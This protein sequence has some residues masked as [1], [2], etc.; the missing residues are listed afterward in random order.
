MGVN[1]KGFYPPWGYQEENNYESSEIIHENDLNSFFSGVEYNNDDKKIHFLNKDGEERATLD[2]TEFAPSVVESTSYDPSTKILTITFTNGSTVEINMAELIDETEFGDGLTVEGGI[3]KI[4]IDQSGEPYLSV[5]EDGIKISGINQAIDDAVEI[6]KNR[7]ESAETELQAAIEA[8]GQRAQDVESD[9]QDAIDQE[10]ADRIADV[11]AEE[12][13]AKAAE[14]A[15]LTRATQTEQQLNHRIDVVND[16]LDSEE[17]R[18]AAAEQEIRANLA[19]EIN[20]RIA[21]VDAE[22]A[23]AKASE[24]E[25][26]DKINDIISGNTPIKRL[27]DLIEK[28]GYSNNETLVTNNE[29][30]VA[31]GEW[32]ISNTSD[33]PSGQTIFSIGNGTDEEHRSNALEIRKNGDVYLLIEDEMMN[34]NILLGQLAHEIY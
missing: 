11:D 33:N 28:L 25:L 9:L 34:I 8:E 16:E 5:S 26:N 10:I 27:D 23:R 17:S 29:H 15:E 2:V 24:G 30:E 12:A 31:F 14:A 18:A 3:V 19:N 20:N 22:E 32:N 6:E 7:A 13:R 4:L 1:K 21:D